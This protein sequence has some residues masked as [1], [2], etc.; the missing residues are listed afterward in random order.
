MAAILAFDVSQILVKDESTYGTDSV[1][2]SGT[3]AILGFN[4]TIR[5]EADKAVREFTK[6]YFGA[7]P[8]VYVGKRTVL[9]FEFE[10]SGGGAADTAPPW[11]IV[12][13]A[14]GHAEVVTAST[15]VDYNPISASFDSASVYFFINATR[16]V[17]T[18]ARGVITATTMGVNGFPKHRVAFTGIFAVPTN[19]SQG[20]PDYSAFRAPVAVDADSWVVTLD[21]FTCDAT[22]LTLNTGLNVKMYEGSD[23][24]CVAITGRNATGELTI[25]NPTVATKDFFTIANAGTQVALVS[26]VGTVAGDIVEVTAPTVQLEYPRPTAIDGD[27]D[28]LVI[29]FTCIPGSSGN[30]EYQFTTR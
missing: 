30:D 17:L 5:L 23:Q 6:P 14:A 28:G 12:A 10:F 18:G 8:W 25:F 29:P 11:A 15:S 27:A 9:E 7:D 3:D 24:R 26:T 13:L 4:G 2:V 21:G 16:F 20:T 1:P 22:Q 19:V